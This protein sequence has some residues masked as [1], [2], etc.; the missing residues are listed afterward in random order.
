[1]EKF[2]KSKQYRETFVAAAI[3]GMLPKQIKVLRKQRDW[4][5]SELAKTAGLTQGV[6][7][8][9]E[10]PGYGNLTINSLLRIAAGFDCVFVGRFVTF[11]EFTRWYAD[12]DH[13]KKLEVFSFNDEPSSLLGYQDDRALSNGSGLINSLIDASENSASIKSMRSNGARKPQGIETVQGTADWGSTQKGTAWR[14]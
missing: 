7:S 1:M 11:S 3:K 14:S 10:D 4:S 2:A 8:R 13:E 5:Q 12:I 9:A 6:V